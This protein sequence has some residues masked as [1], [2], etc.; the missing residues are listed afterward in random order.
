MI[1]DAELLPRDSQPH[2]NHPDTDT[3]PQRSLW[4]RQCKETARVRAGSS[5]QLLDRGVTSNGTIQRHNI[6]CGNLHPAIQRNPPAAPLPCP[7][8]PSHPREF[9]RRGN[10]G[11][12]CIHAGG[13]LRPRQQQLHMERANPAPDIKNS[14][15][16]KSL[17][18]ARNSTSAS[19]RAPS[20]FLRYPANCAEEYPSPNC[21]LSPLTL[22]GPQQSSSSPIA[23][24]P[25]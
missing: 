25:V 11:R 12:R 13:P 14:L 16:L 10:V 6:S 8:P 9:Q 20:P 7:P 24:F 18:P 22:I 3:H 4:H 5:Q 1:I 21:S 2:V 15:A 23:M 17:A 19:A